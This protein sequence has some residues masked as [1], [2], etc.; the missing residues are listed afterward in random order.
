MGTA[1]ASTLRVIVAGLPL[2]HARGLTTG[3]VVVSN[4]NAAAWLEDGPFS[5]TAETPTKLG[6]DVAW[7]S[8]GTTAA[9]VP[10]GIV[11]LFGPGASGS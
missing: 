11:K 3:N 4:R 5:A 7:Y 8:F 2:I 6:R 10:A 9:F 1:E